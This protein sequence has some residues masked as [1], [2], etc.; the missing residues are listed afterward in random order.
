ML[1]LL[2]FDSASRPLLERLIEDGRLPVVRELFRQ[3]THHNLETPATYFPAGTYPSLYSG[4]DVAD[5][6]LYYPMQW[7]HREQRV[8]HRG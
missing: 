7:S 5:H 4:R 8:R 6:G 1:V 2:N 3:G